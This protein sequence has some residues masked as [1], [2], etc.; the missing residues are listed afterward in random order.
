MGNTLFLA[1]GGDTVWY[2]EEV[3][4]NWTCLGKFN[5][6]LPGQCSFP[7]G[8]AGSLTWCCN[9]CKEKKIACQKAGMLYHPGM[10]QGEPVRHRG[11]VP[12]QPLCGKRVTGPVAVWFSL[13]ATLV[14]LW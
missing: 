4:K 5:V 14:K 7:S 8:T 3:E 2:P 10:C 13:Q 12:F 1:L 6:K 9:I 11:T